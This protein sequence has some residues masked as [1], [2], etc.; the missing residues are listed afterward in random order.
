MGDT[1]D[2]AT[3]RLRWALGAHDLEGAI[4][5]REQVF[6]REQGVPRDE[7]LDGRD[8]EALHLVALEPGSDR[9]IATLRLLRDGTR[10]KVGR[11][12]VQRDWRRLGIAARMLQLALTRARELG[13]TEAR[14]AAQIEAKGLYEHAGFVVQSDRFMEAGIPHVWMGLQL[15]DERP[16]S[17]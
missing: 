2:P 11:V 5:L 4:A 15:A 12:A 1:K 14:L 7:E 17:G 16:F 9:V 13:A 10:A 8:G 6:C 3:V